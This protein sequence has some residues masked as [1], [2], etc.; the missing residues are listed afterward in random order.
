MSEQPFYKIC[1]QCG[2]YIQTPV[3]GALKVCT[4]F[5]HHIERQPDD[6]CGEW[7]CTRCWIPWD[8]VIPH[9][10]DPTNISIIDHTNCPLVKMD[11]IPVNLHDLMEED[12]G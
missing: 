7:I 1:S 3:S 8:M 9:P 2:H 6:T 12:D 11:A 10:Q 4:R 5:P